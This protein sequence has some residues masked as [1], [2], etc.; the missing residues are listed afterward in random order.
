LNAEVVARLG[1]ALD[2]L[3]EQPTPHV[4]VFSGAGDRAFCAGADLNELQGLSATQARDLLARGQALFRRIETLSVPTIAAV[5]GWALGG[6]FELA[7][8]CSLIVAAD[9]AR[10]ALP[11]ASLGLMPGYGG[12]QRLTRSIGKHA[13]LHAMLTAR[14]IP[15]TRA[16]QLGL[17]A[18]EPVPDEKLDEAVTT[19]LSAI[20]TASPIATSLILEAVAIAGPAQAD[21][22]HETVLAAVATSSAHAAD[23]IDAFLEK[24]PASFVRTATDRA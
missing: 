5:R 3:S 18:T 11:E 1:D 15:A 13:A 6:G 17:L 14:P 20:L 9:N 23:G 2:A 21:L 16:W 4:I 7:L 8:S 10:F 24:R 19:Q 22:A 12:T